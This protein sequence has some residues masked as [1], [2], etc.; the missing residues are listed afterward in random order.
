MQSKYIKS[1]LMYCNQASKNKL[2]TKGLT[3]WIIFDLISS[4]VE[5]DVDF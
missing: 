3:E 1:T 2:N 5:K 4:Q